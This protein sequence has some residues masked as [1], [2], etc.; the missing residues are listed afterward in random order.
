MNVILSKSGVV[1]G[2]GTQPYKWVS[3]LLP[4]ERKAV[5]DGSALVFIRDTGSHHYLQSGYKV[6]SYRSGKYIHREPDPSQIRAFNKH[7]SGG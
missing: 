3:G 2:H 6:V 1:H 5:R 7:F 4:D